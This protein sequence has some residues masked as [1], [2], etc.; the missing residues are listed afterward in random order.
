MSERFR[1]GSEQLRLF[2]TT[3]L[4]TGARCRSELE[5]SLEKISRRACD[6]DVPLSC[7]AFSVQGLRAIN[8]SLGRAKGDEVLQQ[9]VARV[10]EL[11]HANNEL[12]RIGGN[13]FLMLLWD[14]PLESARTTA[15]RIRQVVKETLLPEGNGS[16][17]G[18]ALNAGVSLLASNDAGGRAMVSRVELALHQS[19]GLGANQVVVR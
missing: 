7:L 19:R 12:F 16:A 11:L 5:P 2:S 8:A 3:D 6:C 1:Q 14:Q 15:E 4:L 18:L 10:R 9:L 17:P 13:E